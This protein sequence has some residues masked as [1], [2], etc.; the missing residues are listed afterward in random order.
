MT[1]DEKGDTAEE[2]RI[3]SLIKEIFQFDVKN[4]V[5]C[6]KGQEFESMSKDNKRSKGDGI[7]IDFPAD[8]KQGEIFDLVTLFKNGKH[9]E[10]SFDVK[11]DSITGPFCPIYNDNSEEVYKDKANKISFKWSEIAT[12]PKV[13][14]VTPKRFTYDLRG[15]NEKINNVIKYDL[16]PLVLRIDNKDYSY[17]LFASVIHSGDLA[18]GHYTAVVRYGDQWYSCD[19]FPQPAIEKIQDQEAIRRIEGSGSAEQGYIY[20]FELKQKKKIDT[21]NS[22]G[23]ILKQALRE[24]KS[25]YL[26]LVSLS[27]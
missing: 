4:I 12:A 13:L 23:E 3:K 6:S 22:L 27:H 19:D 1:N 26:T 14:I 8:I 21:K 10:A 11:N 16:K 20:F 24:L 5:R 25:I 7:E 15:N 17:N 2:L 9:N 18:R